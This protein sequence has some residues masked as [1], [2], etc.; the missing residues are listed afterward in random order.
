M[1]EWLSCLTIARA[2]HRGSGSPGRDTEVW[3]QLG[4]VP[5]EVSAAG[6]V[7]IPGESALHTFLILHSHIADCLCSPY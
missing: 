2:V 4:F 6:A 7:A 1:L 3:T 5:D